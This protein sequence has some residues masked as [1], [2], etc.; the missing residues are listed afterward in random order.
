L[1]NQHH[2]QISPSTVKRLKRMRQQAI[3]PPAAP[4]VW[5]FYSGITPIVS[6]MGTSWKK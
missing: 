4:A 5:R 3:C 1:Q 2:L 6:G